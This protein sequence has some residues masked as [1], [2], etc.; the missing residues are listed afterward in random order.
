MKHVAW[1]QLAVGVA[2]VGL[3]ATLLATGQVPEIAAGHRDIWFHLLAEAAT[4]ALLISAGFALWRS[5]GQRARL[6]SAVASG[7]LLYTCLNS[8]G[9]Y[10]EQGQWAPVTMFAA[11]AAGTVAAVARLWGS[12]VTVSQ[13]GHPGR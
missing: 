2:I 8:A 5:D 7:A 10:A 12:N 4:S 6:V 3:W 1:F 13:R 9:Y 11:L